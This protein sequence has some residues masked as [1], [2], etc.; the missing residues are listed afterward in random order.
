LG[1]VWSETKTLEELGYKEGDVVSA[2][3]FDEQ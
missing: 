2:F 3:V 1:R